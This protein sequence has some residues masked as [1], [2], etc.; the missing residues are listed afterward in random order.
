MEV[1][2]VA[3]ENLAKKRNSLLIA[4]LATCFTTKLNILS[5]M[6]P[7]EKLFIQFLKLQM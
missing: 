5:S 1:N 7:D 2:V 3:F 6:K 4:D